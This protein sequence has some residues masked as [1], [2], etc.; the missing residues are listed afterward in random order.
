MGLSLMHRHK[1]FTVYKTT[2]L[3]NDKTYIGIHETYDLND[4]YLGSGKYLK[5]AVNK[6]GPENFK[7]EWLFIFD[8]KEDQ[9]NKEKELVT[10]EF[11]SRDDTY[12]ICVGGFG[13]GFHYINSLGRNNSNKDWS[14]ISEKIKNS[15]GYKNRKIPF[16]VLEKGRRISHKNGFLG[17]KHTL[18]TKK[19]IGL[20]NKQFQHGSNNS[21][22]GTCWITNGLETKKIPLTNLD[23]WIEN[24]YVRGRK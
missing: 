24:G 14:A 19:K 3:L 10:E 18:E 20:A 11:C 7:R 9:L 12:N 21:Q 13:G 16:D 22:F 2:N 4:D 8:N 6:Y 17:R 15:D 23:K 5:S 1:Y